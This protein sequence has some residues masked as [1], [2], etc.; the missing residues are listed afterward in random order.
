MDL[1]DLPDNRCPQKDDGHG[2]GL[3]CINEDGHDG[4]HKYINKQVVSRSTAKRIIK[5]L[6]PSQ[7]KSLAGLDDISTTKG[8]ENFIRLRSLLKDLKEHAVGITFLIIGGI[9]YPITIQEYLILLLLSH[10]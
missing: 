9:G 4:K 5:Y 3:Q 8:F 7:L 2:K 1:I 6:A 10:S